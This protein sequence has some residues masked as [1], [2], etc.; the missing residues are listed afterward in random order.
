MRLLHCFIATSLDGYIAGPGEDIGWLF[1]DQEYGYPEFIAG[2]DTLLMG[3]KTYEACRSFGEWPYPGLRTV[4]FSRSELAPDPNIEVERR[5]IADVVAALRALPG[6]D[7]WLVGGA[8]LLS[9]AI[10][11]DLVDAYTVSIH[12]ILLGGGT[13]LVVPGTRASSLRLHASRTYETGLVQVRCEVIRA[14]RT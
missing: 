8:A 5:P 4:V 3:R 9:A 1:T 6:K 7:L 14:A 12:P 2:V 10:E 13:P 11:A